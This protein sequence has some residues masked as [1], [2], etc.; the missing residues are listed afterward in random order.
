M[1]DPT[2]QE[3]RVRENVRVFTLGGDRIETSFGANCTAVV[4]REAVLLV[5]P[6]IAPAC[7]RLVERALAEKTEL[8]VQY[9]ALTHHHTDHAL[10]AGHFARRGMTVVAHQACAAR[11]AVEHAGLVAARRRQ[12]E[13][14]ALFAEAEAYSPSRVF[15]DGVTL[16][17]GE[18]EARV[19][20]TGHGHTAGDAIVH[21]PKESVVVCGDLVSAGY[22]VNY[23]DADVG[24]LDRGL[25]ALS[26]LGAR[27]YV[28][29]H[30]APGGPERL[31]AQAR[32]HA[33]ARAAAGSPD[34]RD[35][36]RSAF[37]E[38]R[39]EIVLAPSVEVWSRTAGRPT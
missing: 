29:G 31:E 18:T 12:P 37:P 16:D 8:R 28:P 9:V 2:L 23:E 27:A 15:E 24:H 25:A 33:A 21:L 22:H 7:A 20:H 17:L 30:G 34:A 35:R 10:G 13:L 11:M 6:L 32:Y 14:A 5:D 3:T 36:L 39:L 1:T 19:I 38:H 26:A 4:G